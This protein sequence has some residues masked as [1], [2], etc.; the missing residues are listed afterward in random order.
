M[1]KPEFGW[2][3]NLILPNLK[4]IA[5]FRVQ[6]A[7]LLPF[8]Q[9]TSE[10]GFQRCGTDLD[11]KSGEATTMQTSWRMSGKV[12]ARKERLKTIFA[13]YLRP[14]TC[15]INTRRLAGQTD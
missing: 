6:I 9:P 12:V 7:K 4:K 2:L 15:R 5:R 11:E 3:R 1:G 13:T 14:A 10:L 8:Y